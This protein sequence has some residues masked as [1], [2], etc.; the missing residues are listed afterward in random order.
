MCVCVCVCVCIY[1]CRSL[2]W[3]Y[4]TIHV[5]LHCDTAMHALLIF[6]IA[7]YIRV[8]RYTSKYHYSQN[9]S[10][11]AHFIFIIAIITIIT[12][13]S[14]LQPSTAIVNQLLVQ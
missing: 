6:I 2:E 3:H 11:L 4:D 13:T 5:T 10:D 7:R 1:L 8:G 12:S 9:S 14:D